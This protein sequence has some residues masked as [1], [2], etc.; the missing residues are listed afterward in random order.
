L[1]KIKYA[2]DDR[3]VLNFLLGR[4]GGDVT[5]T[6]LRPIDLMY[7]SLKQLLRRYGIVFLSMGGAITLTLAL[8]ETGL[9]SNFGFF[10][11][12][13]VMA[14]AWFGYGPGLLSLLLVTIIVPALFAPSFRVENVDPM[15]VGALFFIS[16]L[17]SWVRANRDRSEARLRAAAADLEQRVAERTAA[18][19]DLNKA[20]SH[21]NQQLRVLID[22]APLSIW[23]TDLD[24]NVTFWNP[25]AEAVFGWTEE[26]V[27]Y[28]PLPTIP[29]NQQAEFREWLTRYARGEA[30]HGVERIRQRKDGS[31][32]EVNIWTAPLRNPAGA[33]VGNLGMVV[34]ISEIKRL[35]KRAY[36][37]QKMEALG[38]LA[39]GVAHDF[40]NLLTAISGFSGILLD[41]VEQEPWRGYVQ[42]IENAAARAASLTQQL[43]AFSRRQ[44]VQMRI[45]DL[46]SVVAGSAKL[47]RRVIGED[48]QLLTH[49]DP[50]VW[51]VRA[52]PGQIEQ[53]IMNLAVNARDAMPN[54]GTLTIGTAN[55]WLDADQVE[56][57]LAVSAGPYVQLSVSDTGAGLSAEA[58]DRLFEPFFTTKP[59]GKGTGLGLS[60]VYGVVKQSQGDI[61]VHSEPGRGTS[62]KIYLPKADGAV[63][64]SSEATPAP[65][66]KGSGTI[67]VVEDDPVVRRLVVTVLE[68]HGYTVLAAESGAQA[69]EVSSKHHGSIHLLL[70]DVVMPERNGPEV[71]RVLRSRRTDLKV[72]FMSGYTENR[73]LEHASSHEL[74]RFLQ[75]PFTPRALLAKVQEALN[76]PPRADGPRSDG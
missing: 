71:Y 43:L 31:L 63:D 57:R 15:R 7:V 50:E 75:K 23:A 24:G 20:L 67:L 30:L 21:A 25:T 14:S 59:L 17:I 36:H 12:L 46:T 39:G 66:A 53:V 70:T 41:E 40:N 54:G 10:F 3:I 29:D 64:E 27:L 13:A 45:I 56:R 51:R 37:A 76:G 44:V 38:R 74:S 2:A 22:A 33:I 47:L 65:A 11:L 34:D 58:R 35:E 8:R 28:L 69:E 52:D 48:V 72:L 19:A 5:G 9:W 4:P 6:P 73:T 68:Q 55:V 1:R 62:F 16:M 26:E 32:V 42:E 60:I 18:L 61:V 49:L